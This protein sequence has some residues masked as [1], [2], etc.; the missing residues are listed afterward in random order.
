MLSSQYLMPEAYILTGFQNVT[1]VLSEKSFKKELELIQALTC[2]NPTSNKDPKSLND[3]TVPLGT[4]WEETIDGGPKCL[5]P[6][7]AQQEASLADSSQ[8]NRP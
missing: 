3:Y 7:L 4:L 6:P 1:Q 2:P 5:F 8:K